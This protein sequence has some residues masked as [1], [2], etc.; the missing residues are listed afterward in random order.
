MGDGTA[1]DD[2]AAEAVGTN[3]T[4]G[5]VGSDDA[6]AAG[7]DEAGDA[8]KELTT[9]IVALAR[10]SVTCASRSAGVA[11]RFRCHRSAAVV[12]SA[13]TPSTDAI[14]ATR[15]RGR[16]ERA[17]VPPQLPV[18]PASVASGAGA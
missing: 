3:E 15:T 8:G 14:V 12:P 4:T 10:E 9:G 11:L 13:S 2:A 6:G 17:M 18:F 5:S 1:G 16:R 7:S